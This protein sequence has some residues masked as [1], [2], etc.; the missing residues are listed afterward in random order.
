MPALFELEASVV[1]FD[2]LDEAGNPET[3]LVLAGE[4]IQTLNNQP[5]VIALGARR[6]RG[7]RSK[8]IP[9]PAGPRDHGTRI[10]L[11]CRARA[12]RFATRRAGT[13]ADGVSIR[14]LV[15]GST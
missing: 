13:F 6:R 10:E 12:T 15:R 2:E 8:Q 1:T 9:K 7:M 5:Q 3:S 11:L 14:V 4:L